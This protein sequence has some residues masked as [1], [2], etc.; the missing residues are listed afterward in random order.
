MASEW[1]MKQ[2]QEIR[3]EC[4]GCHVPL[5]QSAVPWVKC[6]RCDWRWLIRGLHGTSELSGLVYCLNLSE[7]AI[8]SIFGGMK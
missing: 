4:P 5:D 6:N 1:A 3:L 7:D 2:A 8:R